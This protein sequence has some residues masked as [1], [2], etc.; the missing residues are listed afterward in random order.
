M[1]NKIEI[2]MI[3]KIKQF[4]TDYTSIEYEANINSYNSQI[5]LKTH[6]EKYSLVASSFWIMNGE[7]INHQIDTLKSFMEI[8]EEMLSNW[9]NNFYKRELFQITIYENPILGEKLSAKVPNVKKVYRCILSDCTLTAMPKL[10]YTLAFSV[11][12]YEDELRFIYRERFID[13]KWE[14]PNDYKPNHILD[15]GKIIQVESFIEPE[16]E[17][18]LKLYNEMKKR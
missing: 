15:F 1:A 4:I 11:I 17:N 8:T 12:E 6:L 3:T 9:K 7:T 14:A 5:D 18:S 10:M 2:F 13:G 16:E